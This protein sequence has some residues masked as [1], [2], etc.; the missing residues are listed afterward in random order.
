MGELNQ[1][2]KTISSVTKHMVKRISAVDPIVRAFS[3]HARIAPVLTAM[4]VNTIPTARTTQR[5]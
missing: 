3:S 1:C 5:T 2:R 4:I